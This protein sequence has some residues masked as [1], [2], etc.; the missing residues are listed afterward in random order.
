MRAFKD[1]SIVV[2]TIVVCIIVHVI[3]AFST[4]YLL[5]YLQGEILGY[6]YYIGMVVGIITLVLFSECVL[7]FVDKLIGWLRLY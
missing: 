5:K 7:R 4:W 3:V 2:L 1:F 6:H